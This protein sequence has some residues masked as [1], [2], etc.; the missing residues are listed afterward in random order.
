[1][2]I[3]VSAEAVDAG[4]MEYMPSFTKSGNEAQEVRAILEAAA[5][6]I[7]RDAV[8]GLTEGTKAWDLYRAMQRVYEEARIAVYDKTGTFASDQLDVEMGKLAPA[9]LLAA[10]TG[11]REACTCDLNMSPP[12]DRHCPQHGTAPAPSLT[13]EQDWVPGTQ[14]E[15]GFWIC[16]KCEVADRDVKA[17]TKAH[18]HLSH[19]VEALRK[20]VEAGFADRESLAS[21]YEEA[22]DASRRTV[23]RLEAERDTF[24]QKLNA[25]CD[26]ENEADELRATVE[27]LEMKLAQRDEAHV[28]D[29]GQA[30]RAQAGEA[31]ALRAMLAQVQWRYVPVDDLEKRKDE[32]HD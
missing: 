18:P 9:A 24:E 16:L 7:L 32:S 6:I 21:F 14:T 11:E 19:C 2:T 25:I 30:V 31:A 3:K 27:R 28:S 15:D 13:P 8:Q 12:T 17:S 23:E 4:N 5:P 10:L 20:F 22:L 26:V 1:M 29:F